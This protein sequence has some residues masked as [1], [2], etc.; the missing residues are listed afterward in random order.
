[1]KG[2]IPKGLFDILPYGEDAPWKSSHIWQHV[3]EEIRKVTTDYGYQ[4]IRF[5]IFEHA[6]LFQRGVGPTSDIVTKEMY[7]FKDKAGR[8]LAL[9]PEGT[10]SVLRAFSEHNLASAKKTHK[11]FYYGPMFRYERPQS[12][13]YRQHHQF[14]VE[15]IGVSSAEQDAEVIDL[16]CELYRRLGIKN[17]HLEINSVGDL[18]SR[19]AFQ[20]AF[21]DFLQPQLN[22]LSED[23]KLRFEKNPLRILDSKDPHDKAIVAKAPS[24]L[25]FLSPQ[26][27]DHFS[28]LLR[29]LDSLRLPYTINDRIVRGLDYY[30]KT[31]FEITTDVLGSQN[32]IGGGGRYDGFLPLLGGPDLPGIGFG[33]GI[34]RIIQV[35]LHQKINLPLIKG[36]FAYFIPL[37][38]EAREKLFTYT[39]RARHQNISADIDLHSKKI[40]HALSYASTIGAKFSL[41][42]GSRE[43]EENV[44]KWKNME[45][46]EEEIRP[47]DQILEDL[48]NKWQTNGL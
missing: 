4:E 28:H 8:E 15:A 6:S 19:E 24:I 3:E 18:S 7:L 34:E 38:D 36:P 37:G 12:G 27:K 23:S 21:K 47:F 17:F 35:M 1:M 42:A 9:R 41:I 32:A 43:L 2:K 25:S 33:A 40:H 13:R 39:T 11:L 44:V 30:Q 29:I 5:P 46:Q 45:T 20:K 14:G 26:S 48:N 10:S 16:L 22:K 31:V